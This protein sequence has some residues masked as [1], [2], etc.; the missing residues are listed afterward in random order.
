MNQD[1]SI[2]YTCVAGTL[3]QKA[4]KCSPNAMCQNN[5]V[6]TNSKC[7]CNTGFT[8]DGFTCSKFDKILK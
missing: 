3:Q 7:V 5:G 4:Q 1:C 2:S 8:G 6:T